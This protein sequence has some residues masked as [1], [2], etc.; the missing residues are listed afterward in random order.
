MHVLID[1]VIQNNVQKIYFEFTNILLLNYSR[2]LLNTY[3]KA[4]ILS[5]FTTG[6]KKYEH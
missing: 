3:M 5:H 6:R 1:I 4:T 2:T